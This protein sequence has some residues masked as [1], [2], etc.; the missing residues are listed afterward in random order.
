MRFPASSFALSA[1]LCLPAIA[2]G[3]LPVPA[4]RPAAVID[5]MKPEGVQA[6]AAQWRYCDAKIVETAFHAPGDGDTPGAANVTYDISPRAGEANFDDSQW[7]VIAADSLGKRRGGGKVCFNWYRINLTMPA[8]VDDFEIAGAT[9]VLTVIVDDYAEVWVNGQLPRALNQPN[10]NLVQGFNA[11]NR[12]T[13]AQAVKP[14]EAVQIAIFG[15]NG[16]ISAAPTNYIWFREAK[17]EFFPAPHAHAPS[18]VSFGLVRIDPAL[19][20]IIASREMVVE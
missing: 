16:P 2:Q 18:P 20:A 19:D 3:P 9:A 13:I 10:P 5:L 4:G 17:V 7:E 14:G 6:F 11:P 1:T 12:V 8:R 15:I